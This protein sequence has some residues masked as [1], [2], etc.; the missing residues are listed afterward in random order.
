M[1]CSRPTNVCWVIHLEAENLY[2]YSISKFLRTSRL[3][4]R[5]PK[6]SD[7]NKHNSKS[8]KGYVLEVDLEYPKEL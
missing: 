3:K 1:T 5:D 6:D 8:S 7:S 4:W 2:G